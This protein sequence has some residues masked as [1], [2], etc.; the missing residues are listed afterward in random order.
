MEETP[1]KVAGKTMKSSEDDRNALLTPPAEVTPQNAAT[2]FLTAPVSVQVQSVLY[3]NEFEAIDRSVASLARSAELAI[4]SGV[5]S[6]VLL[7]Y[8]DSSSIPRLTTAEIA[9]LNV[10]ANGILT[11]EYVH[12][13]GNLGSAR[14]HNQLAEESQAD[15]LLIQNPDIVVAPRLLETLLAPFSSPN[16]GM[17]EAKQLPIEHP[18]DY[19]PVTGETCWATT[20]SA[21]I[22]ASLFRQL[23]GFDADSFFLY[24]DDVDF[25]WRVRE[26]GFKVIFQPSAIVFHDKRLS[27]S[28]QWQ[29]SQAEHY[30]SA[31]AALFLAHK[32]SRPDLVEEYLNFF[33]QNGDSNQKKAA[34]LFTERRMNGQLPEP[35]D[36]DHKIGQFVGTNYARHRYAL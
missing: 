6:K 32:W 30:Y 10:T 34:N 24:C 9:A 13:G 16:I 17:T 18:K 21:I 5:C 31:E 11:I 15:F 7:R 1:S 8:G 4:T 27:P 28:G 3:N 25:S 26:A 14:G 29:P 2:P 36:H 22:P 12:F 23:K 20:A 33:E 35:R 19:D